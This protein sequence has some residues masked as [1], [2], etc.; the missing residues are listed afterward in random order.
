MATRSN[1][2]MT[3][4]TRT[5]QRARAEPQASVSTQGAQ[6]GSAG[7]APALNG[8]LPKSMYGVAGWAIQLMGIVAALLRLFSAQLPSAS[9]IAEWARAH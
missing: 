9:Q 6:L 7:I 5:T 8:W 2:L 1:T 4:I 3:W